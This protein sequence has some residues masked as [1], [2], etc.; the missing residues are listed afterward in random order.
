MEFKLHAR[1]NSKKNMKNENKKKN[2]ENQTEKR[3]I[4]CLRVLV[5]RQVEIVEK[6]KNENFITIYTFFGAYTDNTKTSLRFIK[7][8]PFRSSIPLDV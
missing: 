7:L 6:R 8:T 3:E 4:F 2:V 5:Q 1:E